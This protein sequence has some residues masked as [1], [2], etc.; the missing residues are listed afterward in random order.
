MN[1]LGQDWDDDLAEDSAGIGMFGQTL[2]FAAAL[3]GGGLLVAW[4]LSQIAETPNLSPQSAARSPASPPP[5]ASQGGY[6][7]GGYVMSV[8]AG[9]KGH[10]ML[11]ATANGTRVDFLVDTGATSV[12]LNLEDAQRLGIN[13]HALDFSATIRT[14]NGEIRGAPVSLRELRIGQFYTEQV[15][16]LVISAPL[17]ISLLGMSL[18]SRFESF[19]V[20]RDRLILRW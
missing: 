15:P 14:A 7:Q 18:L 2:R 9:P 20:Q 17:E 8:P 11:A 16:A 6:D 1:R 13:I 19:E 12:V 4:G 3:L 10:F 5:A